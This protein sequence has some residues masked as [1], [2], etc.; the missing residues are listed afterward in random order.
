MD[1]EKRREELVNAKKEFSLL[2]EA[3]KVADDAEKAWEKAMNSVA[4]ENGQI[5]DA[6]D[7]RRVEALENAMKRAQAKVDEQN[8]KFTEMKA[9][10]ESEFLKEI[11][12]E[13]SLYRESNIADPANNIDR[14]NAERKNNAMTAQHSVWNKESELKEIEEKLQDAIKKSDY[15]T[16]QTLQSKKAE[17]ETD[18]A[19]AKNAIAN[20]SQPYKSIEENQAEYDALY[21][22]KQ[23]IEKMASMELYVKP[24][25]LEAKRS[26]RDGI[27]T[28]KEEL[29]KGKV[30][31]PGRAEKITRIRRLEAE[32]E[33]Y[34]AEEMEK[35]ASIEMGFDAEI[36]ALDAITEAREEAIP[37]QDRY[38]DLKTKKGDIQAKRN[39]AKSVIQTLKEKL[40]KGEIG[41]NYVNSVRDRIKELEEEVKG[42]D[43]Q[44]KE[45]AEKMKDLEEKH[46]LKPQPTLMEQYEAMQK[47]YEKL[48]EMMTKKQVE[49]A[50]INEDLAKD[51]ENKELQNKKSAL[52]KDI[53]KLETGDKE[54]KEKLEE[55]KKLLGIKDTEK[56]SGKGDE[57]KG[58]QGGKGDKGDEGKGDQGKGDQGG[59]GD[60]G[61]GGQGD[62]PVEFNGEAYYKSLN[63]FDRYKMKLKAYE[64]R[65]G[66]GAKPKGILGKLGVWMSPRYKGVAIRSLSNGGLKPIVGEVP[67]VE[68]A[69]AKD[70][71]KFSLPE[72]EKARINEESRKKAEEMRQAEE[73][74]RKM[75]E[76]FK[77]LPPEEQEKVLKGMGDMMQANGTKPNKGE[78]RGESK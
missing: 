47:S 41:A 56:E 38:N 50:K 28:L 21:A 49:L 14:L 73:A 5:K 64:V 15:T 78:D 7:R 40:A 59:K 35:M 68:E 24:E 53:A 2:R 37:P 65:N 63:L 69:P 76:A 43:A 52:E 13:L 8:K 17:L 31:E 51:P 19:F 46:N 9:K 16:A 29:A 54:C 55:Y 4:K 36:K 74:K 48:Q 3:R 67:A 75:E 42:Y 58:D 22:L 20:L 60:E 1:L 77:A 11:G 61:K 44:E 72:E 6:N 70:P 39:D 23:E 71:D 18:I 33:T 12:D 45:Y 66:D 27:Q 57:G 26:A 62:L 32:V 30:G 10:T 25:D 34:E